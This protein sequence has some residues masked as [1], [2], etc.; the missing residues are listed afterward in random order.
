[1]RITFILPAPVRIPM[2]GAK[3]VYEH[4]KG[5][6]RLGHSV[7]VIGPKRA[8]GNVRARFMQSAIWVRDRLHGV[9]ASPYY[10]AE[11]V[12]TLTIP[13]ATRAHIP[14]ADVVIATGVQTARWVNDLPAPKGKKFYF[15]QGYET[16]ADDKALD[17]WHLPLHKFT[18]ANWLRRELEQTGEKVLGVAPNAIDPSEFYLEQLIENRG[19]RIVAL[20]HRHPVKG[21][22][23]LIR[24]LQVMKH[25]LPELEADIFA[26][27]PPAHRI[28]AWVNI[29]VRPSVQDLRRLYNQ[30]AV[31][32]H[33]SRRE[34][35]PLVPMEAAACGCALVATANEGVQEHF[36]DGESIRMVPISD[37]ESLAQS[38]L[39]VMGNAE[40]RKR[41]AQA[42]LESVLALT[43]TDSTRELERIIKA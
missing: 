32:L 17:T 24:A 20:Y 40:E 5:L 29:H 6:V 22:D 38:A 28:P 7:T 19:A 2:G 18:C 11:G 42:A 39:A 41:L 14:H 4:A 31:L 23:T 21:P 34:G 36:H 8:G 27:R 10:Q 13:E 16:F 33:T 26:A 35:S 30:S 37:A 25:D 1:M 3:V 12:A 9:S 43:W 15:V